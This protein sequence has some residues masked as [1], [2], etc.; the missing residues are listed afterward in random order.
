MRHTLKAQFQGKRLLIIDDR[1]EELRGF[2]QHMRKAG[3]EVVSWLIDDGFM[4]RDP[5]G[6]DLVIHSP[7]EF[8]KRV[9]ATAFDA[10]LSDG[11]MMSKFTWK[12]ALEAVKAVKGPI[13]MIVHSGKYDD[14]REVMSAERVAQQFKNDAVAVKETGGSALFDKGQN[15]AVC[16]AFAQ[17][18][19]EQAKRVG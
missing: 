17:A 15:D 6:F 4:E 5:T 14:L 1:P 3:F 11:Q 16:K 19:T 13:P 9:K 7:Q 12:E 10:L 18:F 8:E 2:C